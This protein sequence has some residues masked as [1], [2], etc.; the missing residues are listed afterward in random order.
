[1]TS[2]AFNPG[3]RHE[4]QLEA[5]IAHFGIPDHDGGH[6]IAFVRVFR[7]RIR[8]DDHSVEAVN[9]P[10]ALEENFPETA[11][12]SRTASTLL[13]VLNTTEQAIL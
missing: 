6:Y 12:L 4:Y 11:A 8:F 1:M 10:G 2:H 13:D 3:V 9:E 5:V 7:P